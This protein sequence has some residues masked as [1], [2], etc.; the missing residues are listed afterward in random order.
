VLCPTRTV[1]TDFPKLIFLYFPI[2]HCATDDE[3]E[4]NDYGIVYDP[5]WG[6]VLMS[7]LIL[8]R[9]PRVSVA[10][11]FREQYHNLHS[12]LIVSLHRLPTFNGHNKSFPHENVLNEFFA[13]V[14]HPRPRPQSALLDRWNLKLHPRVFPPEVFCAF[15]KPTEAAKSDH[16][17]FS[18]CS[19]Y[20]KIHLKIW[21]LY[22]QWKA[23]HE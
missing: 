22:Q 7:L 19:R 10:L 23:L 17:F 21:P 4:N 15:C 13:T 5:F 1:H 18:L 11:S 3:N 8:T 14:L 9:G 6:L 12:V 2:P 16:S 20:N